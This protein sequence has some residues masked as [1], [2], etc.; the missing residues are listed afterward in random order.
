MLDSPHGPYLAEEL[1]DLGVDPAQA[2]PALRAQLLSEIT[3][4][5]GEVE[6]S[7]DDRG[8]RVQLLGPQAEIF[9]GR[10]LEAA[11][12]WCLL[13]LRGIDPNYPGEPA[14]DFR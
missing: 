5:G 3:R 1:V 2:G 12:A 11:L 13:Y 14:D 4:C 8:W 10:S 9:H 7:V 6:W